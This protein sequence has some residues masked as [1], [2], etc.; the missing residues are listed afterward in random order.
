M[1]INCIIPQGKLL[2]IEKKSSFDGSINWTEVVVLQ[3]SFCNT[4]NCDN[5]LADSL[6]VGGVY[7]FVL[8]IDEKPKAVGT[9][10]YMQ[11]KFKIIGVLNK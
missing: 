10:A 5:K 11:Q 1:K 3:D 2:N 4:C 8:N 6:K 9:G 7:D